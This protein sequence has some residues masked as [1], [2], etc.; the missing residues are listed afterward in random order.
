MKTIYKHTSTIK[1]NIII[2]ICQYLFL[3]K[4]FF[5]EFEKDVGKSD[6]LLLTK[7]TTTIRGNTLCA[8]ENFIR[9]TKST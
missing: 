2:L 7:N 1:Y 6:V 8:K 5:Q 4:T 9:F 3:K